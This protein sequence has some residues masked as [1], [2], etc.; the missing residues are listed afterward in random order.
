MKKISHYCQNCRAANDPGEAMCLSCGTPL[1]IVVYPPSVRHDEFAA[2]SQYEDHLLER[3]SLLEMRLIQLTDSLSLTLQVI[4]DQGQI[5]REEHDLVR[6]LYESLKL[7]DAEKLHRTIPK[8]NDAFKKYDVKTSALRIREIMA[9]G[10]GNNPEMLEL[11]ACEA[12]EFIGKNDE[13]R[14]FDALKRAELIAPKNVPL[15]ILY[16]EQLFYA[17]KFDK[18]KRKLETIYKIAPNG[19]LVRLLLGIIYADEL[20]TRKAEELLGFFSENEKINCAVD[21]I[22]AMI[23]AYRKDLDKAVELL[24]SSLEKFD[25]A[26]TRYLLACALF[27]DRKYKKS[28]T[29]FRKAAELDENFTDAHFMKSLVLRLLDRKKAADEAAQ[30]ALKTMENGAQC[31]EFFGAKEN[32]LPD[33]LIAMP[34]LH[35]ESKK[36]LLTG[37]AQRVRKF[38]RSLVFDILNG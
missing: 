37:G 12:F 25:F 31:M 13:Q 19:E 16:A 18:A 6:E 36:R 23:A 7:L 5:M 2:V 10:V 28:L 38:V 32:E 29:H 27:Q 34:F 35:F 9:G 3:V 26:E 33:L 15:L 4:G 11:L 17:D 1:M 20:E 8:W 24:E 22:L 30:S 14:T 21:I